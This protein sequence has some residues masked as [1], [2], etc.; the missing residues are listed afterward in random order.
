MLLLLLT[1]TLF[2]SAASAEQYVCTTYIPKATT[3]IYKRVEGNLF[4][5]PLHPTYQDEL[6][7]LSKLAYLEATHETEEAIWFLEPRE[8]QGLRS[9]RRLT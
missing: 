3:V 7:S 2:T 6:E 4:V 8:S 9:L 1:L 5:L